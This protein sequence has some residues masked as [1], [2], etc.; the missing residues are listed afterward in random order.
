MLGIIGI[1]GIALSKIINFVHVH[2]RRL[3]YR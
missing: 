1:I 3:R 2:L